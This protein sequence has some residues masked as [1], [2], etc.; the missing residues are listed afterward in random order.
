VDL[1]GWCSRMNVVYF[2][3]GCTGG[4]GQSYGS[5]PISYGSVPGSTGVVVKYPHGLERQGRPLPYFF[6][7]RCG[8]FWGSSA[9]GLKLCIS[10]LGF[11]GGSGHLLVRTHSRIVYLGHLYAGE[12]DLDNSVP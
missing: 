7:V 1:G 2:T 5:V 10:P 6:G 11:T 8:R 3:L 12:P 9:V 4:S